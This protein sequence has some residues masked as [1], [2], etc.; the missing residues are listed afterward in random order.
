MESKTNLSL[1]LVAALVFVSTSLAED[2]LKIYSHV[3]RSGETNTWSLRLDNAPKSKRWDPENQK[4]P[5]S[6]ETAI[7]IARKWCGTKTENNLKLNSAALLS[8]APQGGVYHEI[9][10]YRIIFNVDPFDR[11]ACIVLL[12]STVLAP[13]SVQL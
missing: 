9:F 10:Y 13:Q 8:V 11:I 5:L 12:D 1:L 4:L 7:D 3:R 6:L 2:T